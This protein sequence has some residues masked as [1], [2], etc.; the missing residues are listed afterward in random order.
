[1]TDVPH[2]IRPFDESD[3]HF[4]VRGWASEMRNSHFARCV[5]EWVYWPSQHEL[6]RQ[7]LEAATTLVA[8]DPDDETHVYG[9]V[10]HQPGDHAIVH[11]LY[12]KGALRRCG[13]GRALLDAA[14]GERRPILFTQAP[15]IFDDRGLVSRYEAVYCHYLLLGIAPQLP[16]R[17][18]TESDAATA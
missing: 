5:P 14:I 16:E 8:C 18:T 4:V 1:V 7:V 3:R 9:C 6:I 15:R 12:V 13:L 2:R 17:A 10:V 11:W